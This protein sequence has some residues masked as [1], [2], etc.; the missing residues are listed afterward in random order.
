[1]LVNI[2][3]WS[4]NHLRSGVSAMANQTGQTKEFRTKSSQQPHERLSAEQVKE[5]WLLGDYTA[6]GYLF[7]L[8]K[9]MKRDG[10]EI[11]IDDPDNHDPT[12]TPV[13]KFCQK[14]A[15]AE[16]RFYRAKA[17]LIAEGRLTE[18]IIGKLRVKL[19]EKVVS[20]AT[21]NL[22]VCH[23]TAVSETDNLISPTVTNVSDS[24]KTVSPSVANVSG[25]VPKPLQQNNSSDSPDPDQI[26]TDLHHLSLSE[27]T[28]HPRR[29]RGE[30]T[31]QNIAEVAAEVRNQIAQTI[32]VR[33]EVYEERSS[34]LLET[35]VDR[36]SAADL[37]DENFAGKT[38]TD[39]QTIAAN[40]LPTDPELLAWIETQAHD[41]V[42][43]GGRRAWAKKCLA[44]DRDYW[45][46]K[47]LDDRTRRITNA[48]LRGIPLD[49]TYGIQNPAAYQVFERSRIKAIEPTIG[50][51]CALLNAKWQI[52]SIR[53]EA[54]AQARELGFIVDESGIR[55]P[56]HAD[57][58]MPL[59]R[60][61]EF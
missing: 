16:R 4:G 17:K 61:K 35:G 2:W 33:A 39:A 13:Q 59:D 46:K 27:P 1:M 56:S 29:E 23:D 60:W 41:K 21:D 28:H 37:H 22:T 10:W 32:D 50:G 18:K 30:E 52:S 7:H 58:N 43:P 54:I 3:N 48:Q 34:A 55:L 6:S 53:Q 51:K 20:L 12:L 38:L 40:K 47:Y 26:F 25:I 9:S 15:I 19:T 14:W 5:C 36:S 24:D 57:S 8:F 42:S 49:R 45:Q 44:N 31:M 11:D